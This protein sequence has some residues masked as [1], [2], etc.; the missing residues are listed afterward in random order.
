MYY[1][2]LYWNLTIN[3]QTH[4]QTHQVAKHKIICTK[5]NIYVFYIINFS[6]HI[7]HSCLIDQSI[8]LQVWHDLVPIFLFILIKAICIFLWKMDENENILCYDIVIHIFQLHY[9]QMLKSIP[10]CL[11]CLM[12]GEH[13]H[14][15]YYVEVAHYANCSFWPILCF[16]HTHWNK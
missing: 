8:S 15:L 3:S 6:Q 7:I 5:F 14:Q 16:V 9:T 11:W 12:S 13:F 1:I 2:F 4:S 10:M